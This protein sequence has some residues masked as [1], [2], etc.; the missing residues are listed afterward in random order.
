MAA[1]YV[2]LA[3]W[4]AGAAGLYPRHREELFKRME[5]AA[6]FAVRYVENN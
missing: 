2:Y 1:F 4:A 5:R 6:G 3:L